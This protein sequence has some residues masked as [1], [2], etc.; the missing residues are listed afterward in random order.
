MGKNSSIEWTDHTFNPWWGCAKVSPGCNNCYAETWARRVGENIWGVKA[1]RRFFT[2]KHW[3]EPLR[4]NADA[5]SE[6]RRK[7]VFCASMADVFESRADLDAWRTRLW[8]LI[9]ETPWL[10]WLLLTKRPQN[11]E[12][13]VPWSECWPTNVWLGTTVEDQQRAELRLP[14][15]LHFRAKYRFLSCEPLLGAVDLER[16]LGGRPGSLNPIDWVIAGGESGPNARPMLPGW[17]M[18]L[19]DQCQ[20][21]GIPFH[22]KQWGHWAPVAARNG[23]R[24]PVRKFWDE[25]MGV[26]IFMEPKGKKIA[27]RDLDGATWDQIPATV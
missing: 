1:G 10:D 20:G 7:R 2:D 5:E 26:E 23:E 16:W 18:K 9:R 4:W 12:K 13:M 8:V 3:S 11:I 21:A 6:G 22:F 19:R 17:A 24:A 27:G 15:L 25:V 14:L